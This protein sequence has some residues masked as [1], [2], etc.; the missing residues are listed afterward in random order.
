MIAAQR[1]AEKALTDILNEI[2]P[3]VAE[4]E[5]AARL[6]Y[7]M[8]HYGAEDKSFDPIVVSG[9]NGSLPHGVPSEKVI[10]AGEFVTMDFGCIYHGY[11]SSGSFTARSSAS[12]SAAG[13]SSQGRARA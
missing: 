7:L 9:P 3:G 4:K 12:R 13:T 6:Q 5:I 10:Q 2:R 1:I 11:C 8:L